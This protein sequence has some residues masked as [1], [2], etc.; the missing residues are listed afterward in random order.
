MALEKS[1]LIFLVM[2]ALCGLCFGVYRVGDS[3]GWS[4]RGLVDYN[5]WT[6]TKD[7]HVLATHSYLL[8]TI[9][10]TT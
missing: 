10:S 9:N 3:S 4:S 1:T 2:L 5:E 6:S 7:F 8:T